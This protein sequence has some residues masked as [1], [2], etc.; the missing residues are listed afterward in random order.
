MV[1]EPLRWSRS[2]AAATPHLLPGLVLLF[3]GCASQ[4]TVQSRAALASASPPAQA[5]IYDFYETLGDH[6]VDQALKACV[7][8]DP[9]TYGVTRCYDES[10]SGTRTGMRHQPQLFAGLQPRFRT[11]SIKRAPLASPL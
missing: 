5:Y 10:S 1:A 8:G 9:G 6:P 7:D 2:G 4:T 11:I 3:A